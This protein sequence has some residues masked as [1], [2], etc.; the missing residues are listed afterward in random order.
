M[1]FRQDHV[2]NEVSSLNKKIDEKC[3]LVISALTEIKSKLDL[4]ANPMV[5]VNNSA[6]KFSKYKAQNDDCTADFNEVIQF[7][8]HTLISSLVCYLLSLYNLIVYLFIF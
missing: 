7:F 5:E 1:G 4:K 3:G 2:I 6:P 8:M